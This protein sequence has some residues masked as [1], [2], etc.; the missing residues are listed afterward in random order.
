MAKKLWVKGQS[1]NPGGRPKDVL[2][3]MIRDANGVPEKIMGT[4]LRIL[5][6][7]KLG[8][9]ANAWASE[10]LRDTGWG[11]PVTMVDTPQGGDLSRMLLLRAKEAVPSL[12]FERPGGRNGDGNGNGV[13]S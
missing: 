2:G 11:K 9:K 10:F 4:A 8:W 1:G 7:K 3:Q 13:P 5:S 6:N 12:H